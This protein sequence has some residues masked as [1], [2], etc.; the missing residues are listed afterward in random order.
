MSSIKDVTVI[1]DIKK[2]TPIV[3][4]GKPL[5]IGTSA[6]AKPYKSYTDLAEVAADH[7][8]NSEIYKAAAAIFNQEHRPPELAVMS[9]ETAGTWEDFLPQIFEKDWYFLICTRSA[10][11][12]I[13]AIAD[14]V[15]ANDSRQFMVS[16]T[17]KEDMVTI[18]AKEYKNT[19]VFY[20][21]NIDNYPEAALVGEAGSKT[22]G[23]ITW[24][25]QR[26]RGILPLDISAA[27]LREIHNLGGIT[28]VTKA[29]DPVTSEGKTV[30]GEYI[31]VI[32]AKHFVIYTIEYEVQ[33][34]FNN[35]RN[36]KIGYDNTGIAQIEGVVR[37]VLQR[38]TL[39]GIIARDDAGTGLFETTF[40]TR[41]QTTA[42]ERSTREYNGGTFGFELAGAIHET[43]IRGLVTY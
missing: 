15:E 9:R 3:G 12:D 24:K 43:T 13:T 22:V 4:F 6:A 41:E 21:T 23:S 11:E 8:I 39:Q 19:T 32:H 37:N 25:G 14:A 5:I 28:Y 36:Q 7:T 1:I 26:L 38:C 16:T 20:H 10:V 18:K 33:K 29:G 42:L 34:L 35:A 40:K 17:S 2:P 30:S 27:E 31:D